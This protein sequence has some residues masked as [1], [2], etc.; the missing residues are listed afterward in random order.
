M[1]QTKVTFSKEKVMV[2][3]LDEKSTLTIFNTEQKVVQAN[4]NTLYLTYK[5]KQLKPATEGFHIRI[6]LPRNLDPAIVLAA[7]NHQETGIPTGQKFVNDCQLI[8]EKFGIS[9]PAAKRP[10]KTQHRFQK[11][12]SD[13][14]FFVADFEA[15]ATVIWQKRNEFCL[16]KGA[17]L[18]ETYEL[19]KDGS[20]GLGARMGLQ[21]RQ[22]QADK[23]QDFRTTEDILLKSVNEIG[24]FLY[25]GGT[26]SWLVLKDAQGKTI[27]DWSCVS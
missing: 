1:I 7:F 21:L 10:A 8:L 17:K 13:I 3:L 4:P 5:N 19:N 2:Y 12:F 23:I 15:K 16:K 27:D 20:V 24:L 22:E 25:F 18:R 26:N 11:N 6:D 14:E 9:S